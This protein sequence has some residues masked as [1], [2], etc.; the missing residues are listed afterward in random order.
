M[1]LHSWTLRAQHHR[2]CLRTKARTDAA[3]PHQTKQPG[4][5][6]TNVRGSQAL[7]LVPVL[8]FTTLDLNVL[9][10]PIL[11]AGLVSGSLSIVGDLLAQLL[12][13]QGKLLWAA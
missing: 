12:S 13:R 1:N 9:A 6:H 10:Q 8:R 2:H 7:C 4:L 3:G 11:Y 5:Q